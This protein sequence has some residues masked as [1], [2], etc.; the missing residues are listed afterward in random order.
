MIHLVGHPIG[1]E[2]IQVTS[3]LG[4]PESEALGTRLLKVADCCASLQKMASV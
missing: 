3:T 1:L 4:S 2:E